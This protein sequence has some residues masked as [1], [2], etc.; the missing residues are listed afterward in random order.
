MNIIQYISTL[1]NKL[2]IKTL[3]IY[4]AKKKLL[5]SVFIICMFIC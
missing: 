1:A 4:K 2:V 3:T 5:N